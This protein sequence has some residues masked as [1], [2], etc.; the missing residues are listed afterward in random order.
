MTLESYTKHQISALNLQRDKPLLIVDADEVL[1]HFAQ[2]FTAYLA[3]REWE[4][5]LTEYR[6]EYAIRRA[7][8]SV[9]DEGETH[10]LVHGFIDAETHRQPEI[11]GA[12]SALREISLG[13]Q[14]VVLSNVPQ[15]RHADRIANLVGHGMEYPLVVNSG[16]KGAALRA[17]TNGIIA[18]VAF[19]DDSPA[20]IES[21]AKDAPQVH[22]IHFA[23]CSIIQSVLPKVKDAN[24]TPDDWSGVASVVDTLFGKL[25]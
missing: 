11:P 19:V 15:R 2:P 22:R 23:G 21:A 13:A 25:R 12:S 5:R 1:V 4:L 6:L 18:P 7:D 17:I 14:I 24:A 10:R 20:Q 8:G 9:A 16:P 3:K